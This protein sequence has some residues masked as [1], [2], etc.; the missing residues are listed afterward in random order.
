MRRLRER[1]PRALGAAPVVEVVDMA[2]GGSLPPTDAVVLHL[3]AGTRVAVRPSG[4]EPKV[5]VY[6]E[7]VVPVAGAPGGPGYA[8]A[9]VAGAASIEQLST[10]IGQI[11]TPSAS[12]AKAAPFH[13]IDITG[14]LM[15]KEALALFK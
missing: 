9:R 6:V 7:V 8:D 10:K 13:K 12:L 15:A 4:T 5:K 3:G 14:G 2:V 11:M 1:P